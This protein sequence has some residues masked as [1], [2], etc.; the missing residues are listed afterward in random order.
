MSDNLI[1]V[2]RIIPVMQSA[3]QPIITSNLDVNNWLVESQPTT[4]SM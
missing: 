2:S 4:E 1:Q 3:M